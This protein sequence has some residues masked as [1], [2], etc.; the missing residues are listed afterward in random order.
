VPAYAR[1]IDASSGGVNISNDVGDLKRHPTRSGRW[2]RLSEAEEPAEA[3]VAR[4]RKRSVSTLTR[5][6]RVTASRRCC[7]TKHLF[8]HSGP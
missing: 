8:D 4:C 7:P 3:A 1:E 6:I 5:S 2:S